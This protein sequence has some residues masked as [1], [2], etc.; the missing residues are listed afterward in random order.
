[1][2]QIVKLGLVFLV[3]GGVAVVTTR[4]AAKYL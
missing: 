1:M 3:V 2:P 4:V